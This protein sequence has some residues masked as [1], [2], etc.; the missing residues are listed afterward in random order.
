MDRVFSPDIKPWIGWVVCLPL[1]A[2][3]DAA[4]VDDEPAP[5]RVATPRPLPSEVNVPLLLEPA[6]R[7]PIVSV[8]PVEDVA[9]ATPTE[10][11]SLDERS[12]DRK[13]AN[14]VQLAK[15]EETP[16]QGETPVKPRPKSKP[17][18]TDVANRQSY[19][20]GYTSPAPTP[21]VVRPPNAQALDAYIR[22]ADLHYRQ[23][24]DLANRGAYFSARA[25]FIE[26]LRRIVQGLDAETG[27]TLHSQALAAGMLALKEAEDFVPR[28]SRLEDDLDVSALMNSHRTPVMKGAREATVAPTVLAESYY[29][30]AA[31]QLSRAVGSVPTGS[32][33]LHALGKV[34]GIIA[35]QK[36]P[37]LQSA[38][39]QAA[40]FFQAALAI[41]P[42]NY[43]AANDLAVQLAKNGRYHDARGLLFQGLATTAQP[44]MWHNLSVVHAQLGEAEQAERARRAA[45][46][47]GLPPVTDPAMAAWQSMRWVD[48]RT[49]AGSSQAINDVQRSAVSPQ[50]AP[51]PRTNTGEPARTAKG[52]ATRRGPASNWLY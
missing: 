51:K 31:G 32:R 14:Q 11:E 4:R 5:I 38:D 47:S 6:R 35:A 13:A 37:A 16:E 45:L 8:R 34:Y 25:E 36:T 1:L 27:T 49:F 9:E 17:N 7:T 52:N 39:A 21:T 2:G 29:A 43:M 3:C 10:T 28:G 46:A 18:R 30:Y 50:P 41:D 40:V 22:Q 12:A 23:G 26:S 20:P 48:P 33:S 42:S 24:F 19:A 15:L 44:A